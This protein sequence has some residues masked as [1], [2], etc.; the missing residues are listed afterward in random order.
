MGSGG[1]CTAA[2]STAGTIALGCSAGAATAAAYQEKAAAIEGNLR[3]LAVGSS[4]A[5]KMLEI[6]NVKCRNAQNAG[7]HVDGS[8]SGSDD[9]LD[10]NVLFTN[11]QEDN[12]MMD[13]L[14]NYKK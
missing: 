14:D 6:L 11:L 7:R 13:S 4:T 1:I 3:K 8:L 2:A 10:L 5:A 9:S 12:D